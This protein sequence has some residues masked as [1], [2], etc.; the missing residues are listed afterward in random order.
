MSLPSF[1]TDDLALS[2]M[3]TR[4]ATELNPL[5]ANPVLLGNNLTNIA[6]KIGTTAINHKLGRKMQGWILTDVDGAASIY[7]SVG[8][9]DL[10]L[11]LISNAAVTVN[12][13][14]F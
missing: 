4:W 6:L 1:Q 5:L 13:Y 14:V 7:R 9:N 10:T 3:Q 11:T 8:F 2:L 12:I